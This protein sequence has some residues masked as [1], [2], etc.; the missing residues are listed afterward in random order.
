MGHDSFWDV[1]AERLGEM[2]GGGRSTTSTGPQAAVRQTWDPGLRVVLLG[3]RD[4]WRAWHATL[5]GRPAVDASAKAKPPHATRHC[6]AGRPRRVL[7]D[8]QRAALEVLRAAGA[9]SLG[10]EVTGAELR[11]AYR[12]L[13]MRWHPDRHTDIPA[14]DRVRLAR[15]FARIS[16]AY[17]LLTNGLRKAA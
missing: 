16:D 10:E 7:N 4:G 2:P 6:P 12:R 8:E 3:G 17:R 5:A 1:L 15:T 14:A 13:A 11:S 9:C